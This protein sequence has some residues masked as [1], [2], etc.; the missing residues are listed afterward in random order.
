MP[1]CQQGN[2]RTLLGL[3][4]QHGARVEQSGVGDR[5]A[6]R[7]GELGQP[8]APVRAEHPVRRFGEYVG[9]VL[10]RLPELPAGVAEGEFRAGPV[11]RTGEQAARTQPRRGVG[12]LL[13]A[14]TSDFAD[15]L[16]G[17]IT[18]S[19]QLVAARAALGG[20]SNRAAGWSPPAAKAWTVRYRRP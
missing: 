7:A 9:M 19:E 6:E 8:G 13:G 4:G 1:V 14:P 2:R 16:V 10:D 3:L 15:E 17:R 18:D 11:R 20:W 12:P 5:S